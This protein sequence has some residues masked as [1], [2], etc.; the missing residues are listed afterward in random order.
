MPIFKRLIERNKSKS[1]PKLPILLND[2]INKIEASKNGKNLDSFFIEIGNEFLKHDISSA[3]CIFSE[4]KDAFNIKHYNLTEKYQKI[5]K[6][7]DF[8]NIKTENFPFMQDALAHKIAIY[9]N[10]I[11][12][13]LKIVFPLLDTE[14]LKQDN[15]GIIIA[16][17]IIQ[18][19]V[20][21]F[22]G[23]LSPRFKASDLSAVENFSQKIIFILT[24]KILFQEIKKSEQR[25][26][27]LWD[28]APIAYYALDTEGIIKEANSAGVKLLGYSK[29]EMLGKPIFDFIF[30]EQREQAKERFKL[31]LEGK[32]PAKIRNRIYV[33][34]NGTKIF[35]SSRDTYEKNSQGKIISIRTTILDYTKRYKMENEL[36]TSMENT[37]QSQINLEQIINTIQNGICVINK[38]FKIVNCNKTFR[39]SVNLP[40]EKILNHSCSQ[41]IPLFDKGILKTHCAH[42]VCN[43]H[44]GAAMAFKTGEVLDYIETNHDD[45]GQKHFH[46]INIFPAKDKNGNVS[47]VVMTIKNITEQARIEEEH[48]LLSEFNEKILNSSPISIVALDKTGRIIS[49]NQTAK[50]LMEKESEQILGRKLCETTEIKKNKELLR[51]YENLLNNGKPFSYKNLAYTANA[52]EHK[53]YLNIIAVP[54]FDEEK[55]VNGAISMAID[56][57]DTIISKNKLEDLNRNLELIVAE[58]T[59][60]LDASNKKLREA[61]NLKLKFIAD[62]SHELR[63]PLTVIQ[64]NL[65]LAIR[66]A[67]SQNENIPEAYELI[68]SEVMRMTR[69]LSDLTMLTNTDADTEKLHKSEVNLGKLIKSSVQS[70]MILAEQ[71]R[72]SLIYRPGIK[73]IKIIAD[74][75]KIEKLLLNILRNAIKYT[76]EKGK[77]KI[78]SNSDENFA[79]V[80][81]QDNGIG[82]PKEDLP[83]IFERFYRVDKARSRAEGGT[84]LGLSI[85]RWI[86][87]AHGGRIEVESELGKGTTFSV[88]L[89]VR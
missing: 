55:K 66:E 11:S 75:D 54:L 28:Q 38:D 4:K 71:K 26:E 18:N 6:K 29:K 42:T 56:N 48:R 31:K 13:K 21:G 87:E 74:E 37:R 67:K 3:F 52:P 8:L 30:P 12:E 41:I 82:I 24:S 25:Y 34:K 83:F 89:P 33:K 7:T 76:E 22:L 53:K 23:L 9:D 10:K 45:F 17:L 40:M 86:A 32:K 57:T 39:E 19:D 65:D 2:I 70:L 50:E 27:E 15:P 35:V 64:G 78:W 1:A 16:P 77:I 46:R 36:K 73:N 84:G 88:Y 61:N 60:E 79:I 69:V 20:I 80:H 43:K 63:T 62:A 68:I 47:Q 14:A 81:I 51:L 59:K 58:R 49:A 72:I 44:C 85:C 5:F